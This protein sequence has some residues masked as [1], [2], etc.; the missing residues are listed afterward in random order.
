[1]QSDDF[2]SF[3]EHLFSNTGD[4]YSWIISSP[5][6]QLEPSVS[7]MFE[8]E[9][10]GSQ[11]SFADTNR[12]PKRISPVN[13]KGNKKS[14]H[15]LREEFYRS[16][17][18]KQ[19]GGKTPPPFSPSRSGYDESFVWR[20]HVN[21]LY[22]IKIPLYKRLNGKLDYPS[23]KKKRSANVHPSRYRDHSSLCVSLQ[24]VSNR[25]KL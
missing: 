13:A 8:D 19:T 25:I 16:E 6:H 18:R 11:K 21:Q 9:T 7:L 5:P 14:D 2:D 22:G 20:P 15:E 24:I 23:E 3:V 12:T 10:P 1:M 17:F 4:D